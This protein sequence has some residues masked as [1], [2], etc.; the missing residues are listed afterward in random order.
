MH[1]SSKSDDL[2]PKVAGFREENPT[3]VPSFLH[4]IANTMTAVIR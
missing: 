4:Y 2:F 3:S 1:S